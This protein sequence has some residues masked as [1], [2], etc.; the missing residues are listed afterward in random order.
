MI[1]GKCDHD[2]E[3]CTCPD[4]GER[5]REACDPGTHVVCRWCSDCDQH[6]AVCRCPNPTWMIRSDGKFHPIPENLRGTYTD[7]SHGAP[8]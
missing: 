6:Y 2:L 4:L 5:M 3:E 7:L 1:C 8:A